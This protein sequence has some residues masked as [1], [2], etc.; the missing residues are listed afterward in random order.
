[1]DKEFITMLL[2]LIVILPPMLLTI[3]LVLKFGGNK[4]QDLQNGKYVK[5]FERVQLSKENS[6][7]VV[8][9]GEKGYVISNTAQK[10]EILL[11]ISDEEL[12]KIE[13]TKKIPQYNNFRELFQKLKQK[14]R[15]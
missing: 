10:V 2:K 15:V 1:M 6:I 14:G 8:K 12:A 9:I 7:L 11:E 13:L 5:I 3:Y 4:L